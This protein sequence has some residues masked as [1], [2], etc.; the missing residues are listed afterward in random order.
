[1]FRIFL[2]IF[3]FLFLPEVLLAQ[4]NPYDLKWGTNYRYRDVFT[5]KVIDLDSNFFYTQGV[6][7]GLFTS[8]KWYLAKYDRRESKQIWQ[9]EMD[10]ILFKGLPTNLVSVNIVDGE[11]YLFLESFN[12][13]DDKKYLLLQ[14]LDQE[15]D[16]KDLKV[17]E[18]LDS[19]RRNHGNFEIKFS[20]NRNNFMIFSSPRFSLREPEKFAI[21]IYDRDLNLNW[22]KDIQLDVLDRYFRIQDIDLT[23][24]GEVYLIGQKT[25]TSRVQNNFWSSPYSDFLIYKIIG[26]NDNLLEIDLNLNTIFITNLGLELDFSDNIAAIGGFYSEREYRNSSI[27]GMFYL[28]IDQSANNKISSEIVPFKKDFIDGF[29]FLARSRRGNEIREDFVFRH[30]LHREDGGAY[31]IAEDYEMEIRTVQSRNTTITNY[32]YYYNDIIAVGISPLG[33]IEW[34]GHIPKRQFSKNDGGFAS[35]YLPLVDGQQLHI[36]FNDHSSNSKRFGD[37]R[38]LSTRN[39]RSSNLVCVSINEN[40]EMH[41]NILFNNRKERVLTLPKK[42]ASNVQLQRDAVLFSS[43]NSRIKFGSFLHQK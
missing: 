16:P 32:Y 20:Q 17:I 9:V 4:L 10:R 24:K 22:S 39:F 21:S 11:F 2:K 42:S 25:M 38:P 3:F 6:R 13:R 30:F 29:R 18:S 37:R 26:E 23:N 1:M 15:G 31:I 12:R 43:L 14:I 7:S 40:S 41:Y 28:T 35:S 27:K 36:L 5:T 34:S 33:K 19:K 8:N